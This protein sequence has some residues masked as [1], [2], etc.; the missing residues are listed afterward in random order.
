MNNEIIHKFTP[1]LDIAEEFLK[2]FTIAYN[3]AYG[4]EYT[5]KTLKEIDSDSFAEEKPVY[6]LLH[7]PVSKYGSVASYM[8]VLHFIGIKHFFFIFYWEKF[9]LVCLIDQLKLFN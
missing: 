9:F 2:E 7:R 8:W 6:K 5:K 1:F 3:T 4:V